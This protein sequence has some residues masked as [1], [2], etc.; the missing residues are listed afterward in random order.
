MS[1]R[2]ARSSIVAG[3]AVVVDLSPGSWLRIVKAGVH[4]K[5]PA[6]LRVPAQW[7]LNQCATRIAV[8]KGQCMPSRP[9]HIV[10]GQLFGM[11]LAAIRGSLPTP[12][13]DYI[14]LADQSEKGTRGNVEVWRP[15]QRY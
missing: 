4:C 5:V 6:L 1:S 2:D 9:H 8:Q 3:H 12:V 11:H 7:Q 13:V 15:L 14:P 10:H